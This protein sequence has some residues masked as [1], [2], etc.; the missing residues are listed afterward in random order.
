ML[1]CSKKDIGMLKLNIKKLRS[2][3]RKMITAR[4][5]GLPPE[6]DDSMRNKVIREESMRQLNIG[7]NAREL[8]ASGNASKSLRVIIDS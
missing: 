7:S 6:K 3:N 1:K 2:P 8:M 5:C 4:F